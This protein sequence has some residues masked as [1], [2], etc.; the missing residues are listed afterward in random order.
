[1]F[2]KIQCVCCTILDD[3]YE[4]IPQKQKNVLFFLVRLIQGIPQI[5]VE[6]VVWGAI[7]LLPLL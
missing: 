3:N 4:N 5:L 1:M 6:E 2:L 7:L